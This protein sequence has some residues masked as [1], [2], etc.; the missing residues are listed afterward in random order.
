MSVSRAV[1]LLV[2]ADAIAGPPG[3]D[4]SPETNARLHTA[5]RALRDLDQAV[6]DLAHDLGARQ[7]GTDEDAPATTHT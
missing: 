2:V 6:V 1:D 5:L 3:A 7:Q 4:L